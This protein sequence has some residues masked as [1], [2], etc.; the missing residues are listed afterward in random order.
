MVTTAG[1]WEAASLIGRCLAMSAAVH[2]PQ[3][4][5][6]CNSQDETRHVTKTGV[7]LEVLYINYQINESL[8]EKYRWLGCT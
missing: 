2:T 8:M 7:E 6:P 5:P 3:L 1:N 4:G